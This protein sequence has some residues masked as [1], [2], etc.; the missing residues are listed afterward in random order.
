MGC[1]VKTDLIRTYWFASYQGNDE[2]KLK[3]SEE[4]RTINCDPQLYPLRNKREKGVDIALTMSMLTN[5]FNQNYEVGLLI[6]GDEDYLELVNEVKR[7]GIIM[8]GSYFKEGLS[9]RLKLAFD[10][11]RYISHS[12]R[13]QI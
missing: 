11:F 5:A 10:G 4:I 12:K 7:Y 9:N 13:K 8:W 6:A 1:I 3:L 2:L